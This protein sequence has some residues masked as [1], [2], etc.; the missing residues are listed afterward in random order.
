MR[1]LFLCTAHNSLSQRLFLVL[2]R[3][4]SV[5]I[6]YALTESIMIEAVNLANPHI[7]LCP[8]LTTRVP[9]QIYEQYLTLIVHPGPPGDAGPS[10]LD[11][12]LMGDDGTEAVSD[13]LLTNDSFSCSGRSHWGVTV[14]QA[15]KEFDA[16]PIWA[17]DQFPVNI[18]EP[19][20]TK[21][22]LYRGPVTQAAVAATAAAID[23][24]EAA[25]LVRATILGESASPPSSPGCDGPPSRSHTFYTNLLTQRA[26]GRFCVS[27]SQPFR[28]GQTHKRP[29]LLASQ[30]G[31]DPRNHDAAEISRRIRSSDSQPGCLSAIFGP[32]LYLYGGQVEDAATSAVNPAT[33]PGQIVAIR[34]EAVCIATRDGKGVWI[35]HIRR[36]KTKAD[37]ALWPKVP[38]IPGL[39][40]AGYRTNVDTTGILL[41]DN[42]IR[43]LPKHWTRANHGTCQ[44]IWVDFAAESFGVLAHVHFDLYNGAMS[45]RQCRRLCE[46][47]DHILSVSNRPE[48][49]TRRLAA[50]VLQGGRSYFSNGI[51]LNVIESAA[52]PSLE[53]WHNINA[54]NDVVEYVLGH[55]PRRGVKTVAAVRGNCAAGGVAL[56]AA[57]D[58]VLAGEHVVINPAYRALGLHGSEFHS[59]TYTGRC[60]AQGAKAALR[61]MLP[62]SAD[63]AVRLG[64]VDHTVPG[65]GTLLEAAM[66]HRINKLFTSNPSQVE[67]DS[68]GCWKD[69]VNLSISSLARARAAELAEMA[70]DFWSARAQRYHRRRYDFVRKSKAKSTPLRFASHRREQGMLDEEEE[71][72]FDSITFFDQIAKQDAVQ[73]LSMKMMNVISR[74][75]QAPVAEVHGTWRQGE[76]VATKAL[77][78]ME[79]SG[80]AADTS[81]S[82]FS[83]YYPHVL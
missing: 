46:A 54:I 66:R 26:F 76:A 77:N 3:N 64:L 69:N 36:V 39:A 55:F 79:K 48:S 18:D 8:F 15:V 13:R 62:L 21:S 41:P 61:S 40:E 12:L 33:S 28:G 82:L 53:S 34:N 27:S 57:C 52:N 32:K 75:S 65:S 35:T 68:I 31:F 71:D 4:H 51:H 25:A 58:V 59:L 73:D 29:L 60:G 67:E 5:T 24:I 17:F 1:I 10:A 80:V 42:A 78:G 70:M 7:V 44:E 81:G 30:R 47:L 22:S 6:E 56:A 50:V 19:G 83:C 45:T 9:R 23:R 63:A 72:K 38:A 20:L 11:W 14:L 16:G 43:S 49:K 74:Y 37:A 2:S